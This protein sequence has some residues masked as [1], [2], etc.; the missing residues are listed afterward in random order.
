MFSFYL[1]VLS[2]HATASSDEV[3]CLQV[4]FLPY[5]HSYILPFFMLFI[6]LTPP[7]YSYIIP[8]LT[9]DSLLSLICFLP[10]FL[11]TLAHSE[12]HFIHSFSPQR[13]VIPDASKWNLGSLTFDDFSLTQDQM[14][15]A[16]VRMFTDLRLTSK[17]KIEYKVSLWR[18][19]EGEG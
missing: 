17:F 18:S 19:R 1:Q 8:S 9:S 5:Y 7:C 14:V 2:Y 6:Y 16:A 4:R 10:H 15:L 13:E 12:T 3:V 11:I